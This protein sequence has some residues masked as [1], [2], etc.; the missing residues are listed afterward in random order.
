MNICKKEKKAN[1]KVDFDEFYI[2]YLIIEKNKKYI[3]C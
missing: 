3:L 2:P 1:L